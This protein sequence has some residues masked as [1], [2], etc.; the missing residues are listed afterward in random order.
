MY[1]LNYQNG[2]NCE[3]LSDFCRQIYGPLQNLTPINV[4]ILGLSSIG[5][6]QSEMFRERLFSKDVLD[7]NESVENIFLVFGC[8]RITVLRLVNH[9]II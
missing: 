2:L 8:P 1:F 5:T 6:P 7:L 3:R 4:L 9:Y